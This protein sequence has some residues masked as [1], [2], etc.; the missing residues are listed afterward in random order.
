MQ[1]ARRTNPYPWTGEIPAALI[2]VV[3]LVMGFA[4]HLARAI[5]NLFAGAGWQLTPRTSLFSS[6]PRLIG[7]DAGAGLA[8]TRTGYASSGALWFWIAATELVVVVVVVLILRWGLAQWGPGR[9]Q[10]MASPG[11]AEQLLGLSRLRRNAPVIRP[12]L[13]AKKEHHDCL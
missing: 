10:G 11:E 12:D 7:G 9:I 6:L 2:A 1:H 8:D 13:Y 3:L 4:L 5:A